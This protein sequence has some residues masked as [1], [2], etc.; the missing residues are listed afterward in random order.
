MSKE[1]WLKYGTEK[2]QFELP[3]HAGILK[4]K[5]P[6]AKVTTLEFKARLHMELKRLRPDL[7]DVAIVLADKTRLCGY[8]IFLPVLVKTLTDFGAAKT[9]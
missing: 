5:D 9:I 6:D 1:L 8:P 4:I 7:S 2:F 3:Y